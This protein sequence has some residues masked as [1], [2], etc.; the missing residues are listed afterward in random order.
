MAIFRS[1]FSW[2]TQGGGGGCLFIIKKKRMKHPV[3]LA[4]CTGF[5]LISTFVVVFLIGRC[6]EHAMGF[7]SVQTP[8]RSFLY[9]IAVY[10]I[11]NSLYFYP[12]VAR[13]VPLK[14]LGCYL[15]ICYRGESSARVGASSTV[16]PATLCQIL[17]L[18]HRL[19]KHPRLI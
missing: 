16:G 11:H 1:A 17:K 15:G 14:L 6:A 2:T 5:F 9:G 13:C 4:Q 3:T 18:I 7:V 8:F 10:N 19:F 12:I